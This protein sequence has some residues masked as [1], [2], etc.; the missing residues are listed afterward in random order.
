MGLEEVEMTVGLFNWA[1]PIVVG[2][3]GDE[4]VWSMAGAS[5]PAIEVVADDDEPDDDEPEEPRSRRRAEQDQDG[6][7][8]PTKDA[9]EKQQAAIR[10]NN[11]ENG[12]LRS[13]RKKLESLGVDDLDA[14]LEERGIDPS[15]G[16]PLGELDED[17][18]E[19]SKG[20]GKPKE[21]EDKDRP[22]DTR[23]PVSDATARRRIRALER[24]VAS[25]E[26]KYKPVVARLAA[27]NAL[28]EAGW[29]G[30]NISRIMRL[31]D[32]DEVDIDDGE[33]TG[34]QEQ[35]DELKTDYP[36]WFKGRGRRSRRQATEDEEPESTSRR[37]PPAGSGRGTRT[38]G[39]GDVVNSPAPMGWL[40]QLN[41]QMS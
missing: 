37:R 29:S 19:P 39:G 8:P 34:I 31:I 25:T 14:W 22:E 26:H 13:F 36:E 32:L 4:P 9:W 15:T 3:V 11:Q 1:E 24:E 27:Q 28:M 30:E 21:D 35:V 2:Y 6:W 18:P 5:A 23:R 33:V 40:E 12:K 7:K 16:G 17:Q 10:R 20:R 41:S 38:A